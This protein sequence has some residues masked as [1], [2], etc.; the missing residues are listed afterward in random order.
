LE[1]DQ[2]LRYVV[3]FEPPPI[4]H[5]HEEVPEPGTAGCTSCSGCGLAVACPDVD[6]SDGQS[7]VYEE[8]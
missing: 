1:A 8:G 7:S 4:A 2:V 5:T 3:L 6:D